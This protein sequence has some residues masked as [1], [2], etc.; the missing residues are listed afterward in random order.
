MPGMPGVGA[1]MNPGKVIGDK[2]KQM[3]DNDPVAK[4]VFKG[5][6]GIMKNQDVQKVA[7]DLIKGPLKGLNDI[8]N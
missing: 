2:I 4:E 1:D 8:N 7:K 3:A 5:V 6:Q